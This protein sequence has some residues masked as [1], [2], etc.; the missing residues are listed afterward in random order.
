MISAH[1]MHAMRARLR[2]PLR[3]RRSN[4]FEKIGLNRK[5]P[6]RTPQLDLINLSVVISR[7]RLEI[8]GA[9]IGVRH[10][11]ETWIED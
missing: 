5:R 6:A 11:K 2:L 1:L 8:R 7:S 3:K 9:I 10:C 4:N